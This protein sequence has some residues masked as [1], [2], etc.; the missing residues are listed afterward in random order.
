MHLHHLQLF[1]AFF[2]IC[3]AQAAHGRAH[4][5][6]SIK[7]SDSEVFD[8]ADILIIFLIECFHTRVDPGKH[9]A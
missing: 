8:H 2:A 4:L 5:S 1:C 9:P 6:D 7:K 3:P